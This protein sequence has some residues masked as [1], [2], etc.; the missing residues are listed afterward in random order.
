M[1]KEPPIGDLKKQSMKEIWNSERTVNL[2][3]AHQIGDLSQYPACR[4]CQ[5]AR[6]SLMSLYGSLMLDSLT[7]RK[8]VPALEKL[9]RF[10]NIG[11]FEKG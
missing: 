8:A 4:T 3:K 7:V 5:A 11:V 9:A 2:R 6:P 10:Y 1:W